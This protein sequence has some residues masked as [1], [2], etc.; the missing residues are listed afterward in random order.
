[1]HKPLLHRSFVAGGA[2]APRRI[3]AVGAAD[4]EVVQAA[5]GSKFMPGVTEVIGAAA[6]GDRVDAAVLGPVDVEFGGNVAY[7]DPL[8]ADAQGRAV[9]A[10]PAAGVNVWI[11][12]F[13]D[14]SGAV[15][16]IG[17]M[18]LAPS[19]MQG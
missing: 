5:D 12:G 8:T 9:T 14:V 17:S 4:G 7:G 2:I 11:V 1:M 19:I 15:G 10:A 3:V 6:Q 16:D 18:H 13:A